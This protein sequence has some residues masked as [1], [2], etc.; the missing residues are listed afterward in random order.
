MRDLAP[1]ERLG[2]AVNSPEKSWEE[3]LGLGRQL[4]LQPLPLLPRPGDISVLLGRS[5]G[6]P[7]QSRRRRQ[8]GFR[9]IL[10]LHPN[11]H[12]NQEE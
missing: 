8:K 6:L 7:Y 10:D 11:T 9:E 1:R 4:E 2:S 3:S 12:Q 5:N